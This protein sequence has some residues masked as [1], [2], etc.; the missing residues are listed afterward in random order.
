MFVWRR[1]LQKGS[2][3]GLGYSS[4]VEPLTNKIKACFHPSIMTHG[5]GKRAVKKV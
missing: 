2:P 4:M 3:K 5:A 1:S